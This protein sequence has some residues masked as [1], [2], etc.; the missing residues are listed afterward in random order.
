MNSP[1]PPPAI[2]EEPK[3]PAVK[4]EEEKKSGLASA[5]GRLGLG[6][7]MF[8]AALTALGVNEED[9]DRM[10]LN[11]PSL[12]LFA[13]VG[14][15]FASVLGVGALIADYGRARKTVAITFLVAG[16]VALLLGTVAG[17]VAIARIPG[18]GDTPSIAASF[19]QSAGLALSATVKTRGIKSSD[20][21]HVLVEGLVRKNPEEEEI[22]LTELFKASIGADRTGTVELPISVPL[23]PGEFDFVIISS[24]LGRNEQPNCLVDT[25]DPTA[26]GGCASLQL[27]ESEAPVSILA[28]WTAPRTPEQA[29]E[30]QIEASGVDRDKSVVVAVESTQAAPAGGLLYLASFAPDRTG[31]VVRQFSVPVTPASGD[32][33]VSVLTATEKS[34]TGPGCPSGDWA[35]TRLR[36]PTAP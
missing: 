20:D 36:I 1:Q 8:G 23:R 28:T 19:D 29:V 30:V 35:Q 34:N 10:A 27:P 2:A 24:W 33:C 16:A 17:A 7:P 18:N 9:F 6:L 32:V 22:E 12:T 14:V 26:D 3:A 4:T 21:V 11:Q 5:V 13:L 31:A 25:G 15:V